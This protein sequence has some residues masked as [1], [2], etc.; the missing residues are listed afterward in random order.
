LVQIRK[1]VDARVYYAPS[2][3]H[4]LSVLE[5]VLSGKFQKSRSDLAAGFRRPVVA[6][7]RPSCRPLTRLAL[8]PTVLPCLKAVSS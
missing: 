7:A 8:P 6:G 4:T 3:T 2:L 1:C 5:S